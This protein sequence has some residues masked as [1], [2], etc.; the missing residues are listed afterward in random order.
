MSRFSVAKFLSHSAEKNYKWT[1]QFSAKNLKSKFFMHRRGRINTILSRT[2]LS[3][4]TERFCRVT[5]LC[6]RKNLVSKIVKDKKE[7]RV[8]R[9]STEKFLSH[10]IENFHKGTLLCCVPEVFLY[11]K[12]SR[13]REMGGC[14]V[15][16]SQVCC[17]TIP[18]KFLGEPSV[19]RKSSGNKIYFAYEG[20]GGESMK[21]FRRR[22]L[23][24]QS[25]K[26]SLRNVC[27]V[28]QKT[29]GVENFYG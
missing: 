8:S 6:F 24:S 17:L 21:T 29:S 14:H 1:L 15:F 7:R 26:I 9:F 27:A 13:I 16:P 11:R 19:F 25:R 3:C 22:F 4:S 23:V 18:K 20:G 5:L 28:F 2:S 12:M 10:S